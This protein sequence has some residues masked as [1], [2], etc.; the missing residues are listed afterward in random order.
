MSV[1]SHNGNHLWTSVVD[2]DEHV[3]RGLKR[4]IASILHVDHPL[5]GSIEGQGTRENRER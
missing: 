4:G 3:A 2:A 5:I 1:H